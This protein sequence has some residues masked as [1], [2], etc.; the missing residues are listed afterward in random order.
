MAGRI[1]SFEIAGYDRRI[2]ETF[3][4]RRM[5]VLT[6]VEKRGLEY[7]Q[8]STQIAA[9]ATRARKAE[10]VRATLQ[11]A[12]A[13]RAREAHHPA[14]WSSMLQRLS[15]DA[16]RNPVAQIG[17]GGCGEIAPALGG[18]APSARAD[19][20]QV[21]TG[22]ILRHDHEVRPVRDPERP[23]DFLFRRGP[24]CSQQ[25]EIFDV[26]RGKSVGV[27]ALGVFNHRATEA[28]FIRSATSSLDGTRPRV[29][30]ASP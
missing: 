4:T 12:W 2:R 21:E 1:P 7:N 26:F 11:T 25:L 29:C 22:Q 5:D 30:S 14:R 17:R 27:D 24:S 20:D 19:S 6:Y 8:A 18:Q 28:T 3:S 16:T 9:L 15:G 13:E 23:A 10:P